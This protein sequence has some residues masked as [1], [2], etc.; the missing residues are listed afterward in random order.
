MQDA[1]LE[2]ESNIL[3]T[4]KLRG[5]SEGER[6]KHKTKASPSDALG[7]DPNVDELTK[8]VKSLSTK[9]ERLKLEGRE[10]TRNPQDFGNRNK[11]RR[12]NNPP[13]VLQRDHRNNEDQR[14]QAPF[15]NNLFDEENEAKEVEGVE[16]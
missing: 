11:F 1:A 9:R 12:K 15:Q 10:A 8:L 3:A 7:I 6:R 13:Q 14:V 2:V 16:P 5:R 4:D